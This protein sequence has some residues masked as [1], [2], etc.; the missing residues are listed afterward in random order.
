MAESPVPALPRTLAE[1]PFFVSGRFPRPDLIGRAKADG[2]SYIGGRELVERV[3][4]IGLGLTAMGMA[5]GDRVAIVSESRPE[6]ILTDFAVMA[7]GA[8]TVPIYPTLQASQIAFIL[9]DSGA[10]LVA[11]STAEQLAKVRS[12]AAEVGLRGIVVFDGLGP[13]QPEGPRDRS[14]PEEPD[15]GGALLVLGLDEVAA[16]GHGQILGGWGVGRAFHDQ[17]KRVKPGDLATIVY[18]SGTT[19]HPKGVMLTHANI[20]SNIEGT[21]AAVKVGP[22]DRGL[23]FLPVCHSFEHTV[24]LVYLASGMS[25]VFAET[26]ETVPRDLKTV[27]PTIMTA[28][29]RVFEKL[30]A[31]I[32][33][34]GRQAGG[35]KAKIFDW[36]CGVASR[37]GR[38]LAAT[39]GKVPF[40]LGLQSAVADRLV[41][42]KIRE[43]VGGRLRVAVSGSAALR[44]SLGEFF[45]GIGV[46]IIEGYGLTET[47]PVLSVV[48]LERV[49]FGTVGPPL[50]NVEISF[51]PDGEI[52]ARGPNIM[53]GY[54][55]RPA[56][57]AEVLRDGW[58][59]TGDIGSLDADGFLRITDRKKEFIVTSGGKKIAP[60][61]IEVALRSHPPI[62]EAVLVGTD[63][64]HPAALLVPDFAGLAARLGVPKPTTPA[65]AEALVNRPEAHALFAAAVEAVN[66]PLA[67]YERIKNFAVLSRELTIDAGELTPTMK[68]RRR[69]IDERY[70]AVIDRLYGDR[71]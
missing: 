18:T 64:K 3:R 60:Q 20:I 29:P 67:Q 54:Y 48:P 37:R 5:G 52:L 58:F 68:V 43:A 9:K 57:T 24:V 28:V 41:F 27:R 34:T 21:C 13:S 11:V 50:P 39:P 30:H 55:N 40:W 51:A 12:I 59:Y 10:T 47:S 44:A 36:A 32:V 45:Y 22:D 38:R 25:V 65:E 61:P 2:I 66:Q 53:A 70:K 17:A 49:K 16:R 19:G 31:R 71:R 35:L 42:H 46:P 6:W 8:I 63:R 56:E 14:V 33:T 1:L 26:L 69:V 7:G 23:S 62:Q 15:A 4:D